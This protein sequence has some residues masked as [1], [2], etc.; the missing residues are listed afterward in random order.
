MASPTGFVLDTLREILDLLDGGSEC[1]LVPPACRVAVYPGVD[2]AWDSC[3]AGSCSGKD[4]QLWA[5]LVSLD[6]VNDANGSAAGSGCRTYIWT[7][8]IGIVRCQAGPTS[9]GQPPSVDAVENDARQQ[10]D[11][12]DAV[13]TALQ[14]CADRS[15]SVR[16]VELQSWRALSPQGKCGG[17]VWTVR[18][19][20]SECC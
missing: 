6:R 15:E 17:G 18:G 10:A 11:D 4:G 16:D 19:A 7:A 8:E 2:V 1:A 5:N 12:A 3:G 13:Y 14:C 9:N 20:L